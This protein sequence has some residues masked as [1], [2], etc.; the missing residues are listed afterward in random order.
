MIGVVF[1]LELLFGIYKKGTEKDNPSPDRPT[2]FVFK[3]ED[4][5][6]SE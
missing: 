2:R 4:H 5:S 3:I 6:K 1:I